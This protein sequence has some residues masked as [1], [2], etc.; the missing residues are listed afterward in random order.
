ML[1]PSYN[2]FNLSFLCQ[3]NY[4]FNRNLL[5]NHTDHFSSNKMTIWTT[6]SIQWSFGWTHDQAEWFLHLWVVCCPSNALLLLRFVHSFKACAPEGTL[7]QSLN[8]VPELSW[9][10]CSVCWLDLELLPCAAEHSH[11]NSPSVCRQ[12]VIQL[13]NCIH[14]FNHQE[15]LWRLL[16]TDH[17]RLFFIE[18]RSLSI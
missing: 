7:V 3:Q 8:V 1:T 11:L 4:S 5:T 18:T 15:D 10:T 14:L 9:E 16:L 13:D 6:L 12:K 2:N 17:K